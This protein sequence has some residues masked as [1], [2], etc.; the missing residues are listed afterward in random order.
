MITFIVFIILNT[1]MRAKYIYYNDKGAPQIFLKEDETGK[2]EQM[3]IS[4]IPEKF[5]EEYRLKKTE[6]FLNNPRSAERI[7]PIFLKLHLENFHTEAKDFIKLH[8]EFGEAEALSE[9]CERRGFIEDGKI[10]AK[11]IELLENLQNSSILKKQN[12]L[13]LILVVS[14]I[15][16]AA[17]ALLALLK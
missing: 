16:S 17:I 9:F 5:R 11:G 7:L 10:T 15:V 2:I 6:G 3:E 4:E 12:L 14:T 1:F 13:N 8:F